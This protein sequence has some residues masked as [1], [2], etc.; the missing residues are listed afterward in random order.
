MSLRSLG[1]A[2]Y[3]VAAGNLDNEDEDIQPIGTHWSTYKAGR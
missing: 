3:Q 1:V 2:T